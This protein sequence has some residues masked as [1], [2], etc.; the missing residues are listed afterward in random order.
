VVFTLCRIL[1]EVFPKFGGSFRG[2]GDRQQE[3]HASKPWI[4]DVLLN[5]LF[6]DFTV[7]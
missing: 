3:I 5:S 4:A 6:S 7:A 1:N 2:H